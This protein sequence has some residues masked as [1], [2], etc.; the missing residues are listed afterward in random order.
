MKMSS[1]NDKYGYAAAQTISSSLCSYKV[2]ETLKLHGA[3]SFRVFF[4]CLFV[5]GFFYL[6]NVIIRNQKS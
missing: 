4:V 6:I 2:T 5:W 1:K 3:Y